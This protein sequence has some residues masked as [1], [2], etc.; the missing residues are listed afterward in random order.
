[1]GVVVVAVLRQAQ[2]SQRVAL[3]AAAKVVLRQARPLVVLEVPTLGAGA[4]GAQPTSLAAAVALVLWCY[5]LMQ[6]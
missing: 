3:G 2:T 4:A 1:M 5:F 6:P